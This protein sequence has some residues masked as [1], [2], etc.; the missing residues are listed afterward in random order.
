MSQSKIRTRILTSAAALMLWPA[1]ALAQSGSTSAPTQGSQGQSDTSGQAAPSTDSSSSSSSSQMDRN[2]GSGS[3]SSDMSGRAQQG[4]MTSQKQA[5]MPNAPSSTGIDPAEVQKVFGSD[6]S[7]I[8]LASLDNE[9]VKSLQQQLQ[10]RGHYRGNVDGIVGPKTRAA[11]TALLAQ[12]YSLEQRLVN[13]GQITDEI[14]TSLGVDAQGRTPVSGIDMSG[15]PDQNQQQRPNVQSFPSPS[16][17][18]QQQ[19]PRT[20]PSPSGQRGTS[21]ATPS[22]PPSTPPSDSR[23]DDGQMDNYAPTSPR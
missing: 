22:T 5:S 8:D 4:S 11:L 15:L 20:A 2:Q 14:A 6:V 7:L 17:G 3:D 10:D 18:Q 21:P 23:T 12:Q 9:Q 16:G 19:P 13:Q 1:L